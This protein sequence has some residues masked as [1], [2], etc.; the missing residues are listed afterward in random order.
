MA[1]TESDEWLRACF[2]EAE[3]D[4]RWAKERSFTI[5]QLS[6]GVQAAIIAVVTQVQ[7]IP[8]WAFAVLA[9]LQAVVAM[10]WTWHLR[11]FAQGAREWIHKDDELGKSVVVPYPKN[12]QN[13]RDPHHW[14]YMLIQWGVLI[15]S[16]LVAM[17]AI[18]SLSGP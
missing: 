12:R 7:G 2:H 15:T 11:A 8:G 13:E 1:A 18:A 10:W 4:I 14:T 3:S 6:V 16:T 9:L 5:V 17:F